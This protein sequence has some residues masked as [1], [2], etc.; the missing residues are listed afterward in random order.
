M[1]LTLLFNLSFLGFIVS[2]IGREIP[3]TS[4][5]ITEERAPKKTNPILVSLC[6]IKHTNIE[7]FGREGEFGHYAYI[8][9]TIWLGFPSPLD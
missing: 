8:R 9:K 6:I 4:S 7:S 5:R 2:N 1:F 3:N